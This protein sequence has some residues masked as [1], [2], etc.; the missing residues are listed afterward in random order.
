M[1]APDLAVAGLDT[2]TDDVAVAVV[3]GDRVIAE[4]RVEPGPG[5]RPRHA[6]ALLSE[7]ES[8]VDEAGGW[9]E[10]GLIGVGAG[11]GLFTGLRI[12]VATA[13]AFAQGLAKPIAAVGSLDAL[14]RGLRGRPEAEGRSV[15]AALD[16]RRGEAF[17][18]LY[19]AG[20][21]RVWGPLVAS[22]DELGERLGPGAESPLAGGSGSLRFRAELEAAGAEVLPDAEPEHRIAARHVC[23]LAAEAGPAELATIEPIYLRR[24]DAELWREQQR[25]HRPFQ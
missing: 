23:A 21:A 5:E 19:G 17:A 1:S 12:G 14:A 18:A 25:G 4:R 20:G 24:P 10:I 11:P 7:V 8:T 2:A 9:D 16:A 6:T 15:L 13:R 22:P 3:A